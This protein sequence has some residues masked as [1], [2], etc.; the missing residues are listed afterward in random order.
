MCADPITI[1]MAAFQAV[2]G[3][4][5][6]NAAVERA[7]QQNAYYLQNAANARE[8]SLN[9]NRSL[10]RRQDQEA[11][12]A[13]QKDLETMLQ[14]EKNAARIQTAAGESGIRGLGVQRILD[15]YDRETS[16]AQGSIAR[17]FDYV[18]QQISDEK[19]GTK[20][21]FQNRVNSVQK[22]YAPSAMQAGLGIA[23]NVGGTLY[24]D[25]GFKKTS[26][27]KLK[28]IFNTA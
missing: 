12:S 23:A 9:E 20:Y 4:S 26:N 22:G 8:A 16:V 17:N 21:T 14:G 19:E 28:N 6:Q 27:E 10:N 1:A 15:S 25:P 18:R 3:V 5:E 7:N 24:Q 11:M 2:K 13:A